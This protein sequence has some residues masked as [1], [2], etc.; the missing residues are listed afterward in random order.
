MADELVPLEEALRADLALGSDTQCGC[1][2]MVAT[3][4]ARKAMVIAVVIGA[5]Q[6]LS[7]LSAIIAY[8]STTLPKSLQT[9]GPVLIG[10][11]LFLA[12]F[13]PLVLMDR[14]G[15]RPL[16][17]MSSIVVAASMVSNGIYFQFLDGEGPR[18][19]RR[20]D[21]HGQA[22]ARV[23]IAPFLAAGDAGGGHS[24]N[25]TSPGGGAAAAGGGDALGLTWVP[26]LGL[27]V[28]AVAYAL[29]MGPV[30]DILPGEVFPT[31]AKGLAVSAVNV[32]LTLFTFLV[33]KIYNV[34][35]QAW[36]PGH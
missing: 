4:G 36:P 13:G 6:R 26:L 22:D 30:P 14:L 31:S 10:A 15:R 5:L 17:I 25:A 34:R 19:D 21:P 28:Y 9:L 24:G 29:G 12:S 8:T 23:L 33:S 1:W 35:G 16:L 32:S 18:A 2:S 11:V 3:K 7:G 20:T 27:M